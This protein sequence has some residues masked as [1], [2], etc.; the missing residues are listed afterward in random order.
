[1]EGISIIVP[2][3]NESATIREVILGIR[4]AMAVLGAPYELLVVD[5]GSTD[6]TGELL[7][8]E[9]VE[10]IS[11]SYN[12]GYGAA[13]KAGIRHA[14]HEMVILI[15][16]D[17]QHKPSDI[18]W[19]VRGMDSSDMVVGKRDLAE[20]PRLIQLGKILLG[21]VVQYLMGLK[22]PDLN[23]GFRA[24]KKDY[25]KQF[26]YMMPNGYSFSTTI[27]MAFLSEGYTVKFV[28]VDTLPRTAGRGK[29]RPG[30]TGIRTLLLM[31]RVIILFNPMKVFVPISAVFLLI[32]A[33]QTLLNIFIFESY[34]IPG[35]AI[36]SVSVGSFIF[37][38]AL[39]SEQ[40]AIS[41]R[42]LRK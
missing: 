16:G 39:L 6:G 40:I 27:T 13:L 22:V 12:K 7:G 5:D 19:L 28:P 2:V 20:Q 24:M 38:F 17:G 41:M 42:G 37:C 26:L 33:L 23:S 9:E 15:D 3:F 1:M 31:L 14:K 21:L 32:G 35:G 4:Q 29:L 8:K 18:A 10:V 30:R 36:I 25:V 34:R 11:N